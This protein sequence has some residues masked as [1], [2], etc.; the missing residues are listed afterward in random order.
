MYE[1]S[2]AGVSDAERRLGSQVCPFS[3]ESANEDVLGPPV[4]ESG[5]P[6]DSRVGEFTSVWAGRRT[7]D[8]A[9]RGSSSGG[10]TSWLLS[11]LLTSGAID[12]VIHVGAATGSGE[13]FE[14]V[15]ST[16]VDEIEARRKSQYYSTTLA[17]VVAAVRGDG[18]RYAIVGV[19]CFIR[20]ARN[21]ARVDAE[22]AG[23]LAYYVGIVCGHLKSQFFAEAAAWQSGTKPASLEAIDFRVK[24]PGRPA[25]D[26]DVGHRRAGE[27]ELRTERNLDL[28]GSNWGH[29]AFQPE[30]CNFCDDVFAETADVVLGDAWIEPFQSDWRGTNVV[31]SRRREIDALLRGAAQAGE[32]ELSSLSLE[33]AVDSQAGNF[34]HRRD[35]LRVRLADDIAQGLSV[36]TKR[37][38]P[39]LDHVDGTR[40][41]IIRQR[42]RMSAVSFE[43]FGRAKATG[44]LHIYMRGMRREADRYAAITEGPVKSA[45]R[46]LRGILRGRR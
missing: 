22:L 24:A 1:A 30:A 42:R 5:R 4:A 43:L 36:P 8:Q 46:R 27:T 19:P 18:R 13:L 28:L 11:T 32:V 25:W 20:A 17:D 29:G 6:R 31:V 40:L 15:V 41:E 3:D 7:D 44:D 38:E 16:S 26:Y 2:L 34:R 37:V 10:L 14:Y 9:L 35:G 33:E 21:L 45:A 12:G 39:G 23:Q